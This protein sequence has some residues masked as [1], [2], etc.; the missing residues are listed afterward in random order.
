MPTATAHRGMKNGANAQ[1][2][3]PAKNGAETVQRRYA[4]NFMISSFIG[5]IIFIT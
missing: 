5:Y 2:I 4:V 3:P 1:T